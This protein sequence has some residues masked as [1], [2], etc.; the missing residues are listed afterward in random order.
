MK[1]TLLGTTA[2]VAAGLM[3]GS[4]YAADGGV[5]LGIGGFYRGAYGSHFDT[6][7]DGSGG[8]ESSKLDRADVVKQDI[9]VHFKG[10]AVLD[11]G[12]TVGARVELEGQTSGDQIDATYAYISGGVGELR[13]GDDGDAYAKMCYLVPA[14]SHMFGADSPVFNFS[15]AGVF[16][17]GA[18]NGTCYGLSDNATKLIYFSPVFGGFQ[19]A[20][21]YAPDGTED[22]RNTL[23]GFGTRSDSDTPFQNSEEYSAA[24]QFDRDFNGVHVVLGGGAAFVQDIEGTSDCPVATVPGVTCVDSGDVGTPEHY[25]AYGR[26][27][28]GLGDGTL[29]VGGAWALRTNN[30]TVTVTTLTTATPTGVPGVSTITTS[31]GVTGVNTGDNQVYGVGITYA[32]DAWGVGVGWTHGDYESSCGGGDGSCTDTHDVIELDGTYA[33]GPGVDIDGMIAY[34]DYDGD[35]GNNAKDLTSFQAGVG[36][37]IGF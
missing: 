7:D 22:T 24:V 18:T 10:E 37:N 1:H 19:F 21:S 13:I 29:T 3:V 25:N 17:Y 16:G 36:L 34:D 26:V 11:N 33:L 14:A 9:E 30:R 27:G 31:S 8:V 2:L 5:K 32:L 20:L 15:N 12:L 23:N 4:A 35:D 6:Q 28:F